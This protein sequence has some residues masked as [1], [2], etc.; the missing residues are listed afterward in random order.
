MKEINEGLPYKDFYKPQ[1]GIVE[2]KVCSVSG[3]L[4]TSECGNHITTK[5]FLEG[6]EPDS[7]CELHMNR[8]TA[9]VIGNS[10]LETERLQAGLKGYKLNDDELKLDLSF[11]EKDFIE[12]EDENTSA[13]MSSEE[14]PVEEGLPSFNY[15][16][17]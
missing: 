14:E 12:E 5:Y 17:E 9:K 11:L 3:Q 6:T 4:P 16:F 1:S 2:A 10:R 7:L 8:V 13:S 15:L